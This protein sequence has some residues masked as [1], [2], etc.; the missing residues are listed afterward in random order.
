[1][2]FS[3]IPRYPSYKISSQGFAVNESG[4]SVLLAESTDAQAMVVVEG[5]DV[6]ALG[7]GTT[8][9][10]FSIDLRTTTPSSFLGT[11]FSNQVSPPTGLN[12]TWRGT[13]HLYSN[14]RIVL[15]S[16]AGTWG[17]SYFGF[18]TAADNVVHT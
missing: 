17:A 8:T 13:W 3:E 18:S 6:Y 15:T 9:E 1:M 4:G 2:T 10:F 12:F 7:S 5:I 11:I 14:Q 16:I